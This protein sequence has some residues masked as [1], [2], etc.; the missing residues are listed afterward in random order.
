[1]KIG[2][3]SAVIVIIA[4]AAVVPTAGQ[5]QPLQKRTGFVVVPLPYKVGAVLV[6]ACPGVV[7]ATTMFAAQVAVQPEF[8]IDPVTWGRPF[9][10]TPLAPAS[11]LDISFLVGGGSISYAAKLAKGESGW[12]PSGASRAVV[13]LRTG[14]PTRF[15]YLA[16]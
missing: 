8:A 15:V 10:L 4:L 6:E 16:G 14:L 1:M 3:A 2:R 9:T 5:A 12:V 7:N 11:N 13:C